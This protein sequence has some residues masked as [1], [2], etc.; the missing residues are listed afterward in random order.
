MKE[1]E[2]TTDPLPP[3]QSCLTQISAQ[4]KLKSTTAP[5]NNE[6]RSDLKI[7]LISD[8][9]SHQAFHKGVHSF[10]RKEHAPQ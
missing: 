6:I 10:D 5:P 2:Q 1:A 8:A 9:V 7:R 4:Q 3:E